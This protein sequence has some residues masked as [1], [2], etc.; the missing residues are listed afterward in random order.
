MVTGNS[1]SVSL[2]SGGFSRLLYLPP[3]PDP[4]GPPGG[5]GSGRWTE[6]LEE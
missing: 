6:G 4:K 5:K 2:N 3:P 1:L